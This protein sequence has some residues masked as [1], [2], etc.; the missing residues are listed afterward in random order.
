MIDR[1]WKIAGKVSII[2]IVI[3][4]AVIV[5][6]FLGYKFIFT[7]PAVKPRET[8]PLSYVI[9]FKRQAEYLSGKIKEGDKVVDAIKGLSIGEVTKVAEVQ[10]VAEVFSE[11]EEKFVLAAV[12][13]HLDIYVT[14]KAYASFTE[15]YTMIGTYDIAVGKKVAIKSADFAR[16]GHI[17]AMYEVK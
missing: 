11:R 8:M 12:P 3:I 10:A 9:E 6:G 7:S 14:V 13:E 4:V 17:V 1:K 5:F 16:E 15:E 2:D